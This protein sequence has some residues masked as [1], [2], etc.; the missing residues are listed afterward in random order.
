MQIKSTVTNQSGETLDVVYT[1]IE[2]ELDVAHKKIQ[3][4]HAYCFY[5][6]ALVLVY[7]AKKDSWT[8]PGGSVEAGESIQVAVEREVKEE[9][10]MR[11]LKQHPI[12]CQDIIGPD[13]VVSQI[14]SVCVVE[15]YG[16]FVSDP[17]GEITKITHIDPKDYK[18]YFD[19]GE[20][21]DHVMKRALEL[22]AQMEVGMNYIQ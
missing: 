17:D 6:D 11:V 10:N 7:S 2:S 22:K 15:P 3:G 16:D 14:R 13:G 8:P 4:V 9:T 20:I 21:G 19:W 12:G 18:K 1:D 5:G